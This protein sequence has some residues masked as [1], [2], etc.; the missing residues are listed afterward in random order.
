MVPLIVITDLKLPKLAATG[1]PMVFF[2]DINVV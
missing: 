1:F 2:A